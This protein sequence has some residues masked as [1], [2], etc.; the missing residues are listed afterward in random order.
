MSFDAVGRSAA[1]SSS[2]A[3][4]PSPS[5]RRT[6]PIKRA[7]AE[8]L[9]RED[10]Q[11]D[12]LKAIFSDKRAVFTSHPGS[13]ARISR[14]LTF[15][16]LYSLAII[17]SPRC[18]K[19]LR[20]KMAE[21]PEF[22]IDFAKISLLANV[23][24]IN[25]TMAFFP[26]MRTVLRSYHPIPSLQKTEENL[27]DAPRIKN[28]L[29][30]C[31]LSSEVDNPPTTLAAIIAMKENGVVPTT[32]VVNLVF[33]LSSQAISVSRQH[34]DPPFDFLDIFLPVNA[35]STSRARAFLWLMFHYLESST[36]DNPFADD[37]A[38]RYPGKIP[39]LT[40]LTPRHRAAENVDT[41]EELAFG[42][43]MALYRSRFLQ[44]QIAEEERA[45]AS[46]RGEVGMRA[47]FRVST[48]PLP[49]Q[50]TMN[51]I[52]HEVPQ[53]GTSSRDGK[54][55]K[56]KS[57]D[58]TPFIKIAPQPSAPR[59]CWQS[60]APLDGQSMLEYA[61]RVALS[62]DALIASDEEM[63]DERA[64]V[65]YERRIHILNTKVRQKEL[66]PEPDH[67]KGKSAGYNYSKAREEQYTMLQ[68][69][70]WDL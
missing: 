70:D 23:G 67:R 63:C 24:R 16:E 13:N 22:A 33:I 44:K 55:N 28:C 3:A 64:R 51:R 40:I 58:P 1:A 66:T 41:E 30:A 39:R 2:L 25:T 26:E 10:I 60:P 37:Y 5:S 69:M 38:R 45:K 48:P 12:L 17:A 49:P 42:R 68:R 29:K 50:Y 18:S 31:L 15:C 65:D 7:D 4:Q 19:I 21:T 34:F 9:S 62:H 35:S 6:L 36:V 61:W 57:S 14:N 20:E 32:N 59:Q 46:I 27:Q 53:V 8:P 52:T 54:E 43:K 11:Y 47:K 56:Y